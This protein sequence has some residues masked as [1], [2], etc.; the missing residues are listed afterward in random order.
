M[1]T[2]VSNVKDTLAYLK[3]NATNKGVGAWTLSTARPRRQHLTHYVAKLDEVN[4]C[5]SAEVQAAEEVSTRRRNEA[6]S[7]MR[8]A[9]CERTRLLAAWR[10]PHVP[11]EARVPMPFLRYMIENGLLLKGHGL[12]QEASIVAVHDG[13]GAPLIDTRPWVLCCKADGPGSDMARLRCAI[14]EKRIDDA[15]A[16]AETFLNQDGSRLSCDTHDSLEEL[17][18]VPKE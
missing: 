17:A 7:D 18:W 11:A 3:A 1:A 12:K 6:T 16:Q 4:A 8:R 15:V 5:I 9:Q 10:S 14:G 13:D 2:W